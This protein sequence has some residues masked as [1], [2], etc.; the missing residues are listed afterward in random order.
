MKTA[1]IKVQ[2]LLMIGGNMSHMKHICQYLSDKHVDGLEQQFMSSRPMHATCLLPLHIQ[3]E[4]SALA[5]RSVHMTLAVL[6]WRNKSRRV[7]CSS[8]LHR[9]VL[10]AV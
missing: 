6:P 7:Q 8:G 5:Y 10:F 3:L 9:K 1:Q 4:A 2:A